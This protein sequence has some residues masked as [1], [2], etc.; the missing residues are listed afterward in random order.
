MKYWLAWSN[1]FHDDAVA[2]DDQQN[3]CC[4]NKLRQ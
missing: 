1:V 2:A 3:S 4:I